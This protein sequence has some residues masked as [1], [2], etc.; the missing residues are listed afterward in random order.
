MKCNVYRE[1]KAN[2]DLH[3]EN[4]MKM[5]VSIAVCNIFS[6]VVNTYLCQGMSTKTPSGGTVTFCCLYSSKSD[7]LRENVPH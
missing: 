6:G 2:N 7:Y 5:K 4:R 1:R 3:K